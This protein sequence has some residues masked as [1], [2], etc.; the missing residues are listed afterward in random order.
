[1]EEI[2]HRQDTEKYFIRL[3]MIF[4]CLI[5]R[6]TPAEKCKIQM[7]GHFLEWDS[8]FERE[9]GYN[10]TMWLDSYW[11]RCNNSTACC[12]RAR[13]FMENK[14]T[15]QDVC[16]VCRSGTGETQSKRCLR[17]FRVRLG[18]VSTGMC[19]MRLANF[20]AR[21]SEHFGY[22]TMCYDGTDKND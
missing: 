20:F 10:V 12:R 1:M 3:G 13:K 9:S 22:H 11:N 19:D 8:S 18:M 21:I 2:I 14:Q 7:S 6:R 16:F 5:E 17:A 15:A 4:G